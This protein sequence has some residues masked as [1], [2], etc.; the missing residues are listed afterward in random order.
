MSKSLCALAVVLTLATVAPTVAQVGSQQANPYLEID[1]RILAEVYTSSAPMDNLKELCDVHGS[2]FPGLPGDKGAVDYIVE[3]WKEYDLANVHAE[4][5]TINGWTRGPATLEIVSPIRRSFDVISL[6]HSIGDK[7]EGELVFIGDGAIEDYENRKDEIEGNIVM[8]TSAN[9]A[10]M[11]RRLHRSEKYMRSV[12][13]GATGW[14]FMNHYPAYGPPTG[15]INP[16]IPAIGI[17]YED[18]AFLSRLLEREKEVVVRIET[19]DKNHDVVTWNVVADVVPDHPV[20]DEYVIVGSHLDGHDI[21]QGATDP[22]S[23][24][25]T[26]MEIARNLALVKDKLKRRVRCMTFG[27]EE[28]GLYGSYAYAAAHKDELGKCRFMLNLD[29]AGRAGK[30]GV[31]FHD[32]PT[33]EELAKKWRAE[34]VADM[35][36]S[37]GVSPYS[38]H[39]PFFLESVPCGSG[40]D[41]TVR[42]TGR[43]YG[44]TR[45]D[46]IDKVEMKYLHLAAANYTRFLFRVANEDHWNPRR[47]TKVE[48]EAFIK[49]QGY[50]KTVALQDQMKQYIKD[51]YKEIHPDTQ[52]W[53]AGSQ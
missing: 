51:N 20:D 17:A 33:L 44:H 32:F 22:A 24:A 26:V 39:W 34:M 18:G 8:V 2:R 9:P 10:S 5:F 12:M 14:I 6:P 43:G 42:S 38:D 19:T 23:G 27:A 25:V 7:V 28:I 29:S 35:P 41:P 1:K 48:I 46:T 16:V 31:T 45:Y 13:A 15:G 53:I 52:R 50:D 21:S 3:T 36:T 30:K 11:S 49:E 37:Q 47:K 40:S 4:E